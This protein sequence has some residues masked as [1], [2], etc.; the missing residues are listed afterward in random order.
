MKKGKRRYAAAIVL[1]FL[2]LGALSVG[3]IG[4]SLGY[5]SSEKLV[6][7]GKIRI[8]SNVQFKILAQKEGWPGN[9]TPDDPYIIEGYSIDA[10]ASGP[11]IYIANTTVY[12]ILRNNTIYNV[13]S[14]LLIGNMVMSLYKV[15]YGIMLINVKHGTVE[16]NTLRDSFVGI[17][18]YSSSQ[19]VIRG[20]NVSRAAM[21]IYLDIMSSNN[22]V[23]NNICDVI[24]SGIN[25]GYDSN[26]NVVKDNV[27]RG[28]VYGISI[29]GGNNNVFY[30]NSMSYGGIV[31]P[32]L[33]VSSPE[34]LT[35]QEIA[36]NNTLNGKPVYYYKNNLTG[37]E[38]PQ[39]AG[40]VIA[41]EAKNLKMENIKF[42]T[43]TAVYLYG[44]SNFSVENCSFS[45][46]LKL[47]WNV[48]SILLGFSYGIM[49]Q[50]SQNVTVSNS[51]F[52]NVIFGA[53]ISYYSSN[54]T[55]S[56]NVFRDIIGPISVENS[57]HIKLRRNAMSNGSIVIFG[58]F[59]TYTTQNI[60][61]DNTVNGKPVYYYKNRDLKNATVP[62]DA[63]E[64][65]LGN[66]RNLI[67]KDMVFSNESGAIFAGYSSNILVENVTAYNTLTPLTFQYT[68]DSRIWDGEW[69]SNEMYG[70]Y[71][72]SSY[73]NTIEGNVFHD[74]AYGI[75]IFTGSITGEA[76][77]TTI[78][79]NTFY[80]NTY[81]VYLWGDRN[82]VE[83]NSF[84]DN[85]YGIA[86]EFGN[87]NKLRGNVMKN[88]GIMIDGY[89]SFSTQDIDTS[90]T[91]NGKPV[92][93][94]K[95]Q[96]MHN[97]VIS[98]DA[99]EIIVGNVTNMR[100]EN[101]EISNASI[102]ILVGTST[103]IVISNT[104]LTGNGVGILL[105]I[106]YQITV[107]NNRL[108]GN[109]E[110]INMMSTDNS[111]IRNNVISYSKGYGINV[112]GFQ[113]L[114][115]GNYFYYNHGSGDVYDPAHIQACDN[116]FFN[117]WNTTSRGNYWQ[118]WQAPDNNGDG[119]VDL[120]YVI[121]GYAKA[122][123]YLPMTQ[124]NIP[125]FSALLPLLIIVATVLVYR[126]RKR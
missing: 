86:I 54:I 61:S 101:V 75:G 1:I 69:Y 71:L 12:F 63:G 22:T 110:G 65:I 41:I 79:N 117:K 112:T 50:S 78:K 92:Y 94:Y 67:I 19:N 27:I 2:L 98:V 39:D 60:T 55:L 84:T 74:Q 6:A 58:D 26:S 53:Y 18:L 97:A 37:G 42:N 15:P 100:I 10:H 8:N 125:E 76:S 16:N 124:N 122:K 4:S 32:S 103:N 93:Y 45:S 14:K 51:T 21:G 44:V 17:S 102:G 23:V 106:S 68:N 28:S 35:T 96:D 56:D 116:G 88:D 5:K 87:Y 57:Y 36:A 7:H 115:Y 38:V 120:P 48:T 43:T 91:V 114:I 121:D 109:G 123:D 29:S 30:N 73:R 119:I 47:S 49:V 105:D 104:T 66:V 40:E 111:V 89:S 34:S 11:A 33:L 113:N 59:A 13:S 99:G 9:G 95:N 70:L 64:V 82:V 25:I 80:N 24:Y 46:P 108:T 107:E 52:E 118:D 20:N 126:K 81:G 72:I 77:F 62:R 3:F 83:N 31:F 90:N 85:K